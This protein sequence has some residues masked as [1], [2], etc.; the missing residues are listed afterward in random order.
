[1]PIR[2]QLYDPVVYLKT[3]EALNFPTYITFNY[4]SM[5]MSSL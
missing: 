4:Q 2:I 5:L 3:R 1:M